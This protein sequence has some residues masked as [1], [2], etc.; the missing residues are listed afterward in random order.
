ML[1]CTQ[2]FAWD[3]AANFHSL[4][5]F[6]EHRFYG[7]SLP[8]GPAS[9]QDAEHLQFLSSEQ[10][11]ADFATVITDLKVCNIHPTRHTHASHFALIVITLISQ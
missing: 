2:G 5:V 1:T 10:A 11:L 9:Y 8:F 3:L 4:L 7:E 6:I